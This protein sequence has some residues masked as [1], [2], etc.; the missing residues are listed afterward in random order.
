MIVGVEGSRNF[1]DYSIFLRGM[2]TALSSM[3]ENDK[4][5]TIMSAGPVRTNEMVME[6]SNVSERTLKSLGIKV[7][8]VKVPHK[9]FLKNMHVIDHFLYFTLPKETISELVREAEDKDVDVGVY[10]YP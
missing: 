2:R 8:V 10:R 4:Q 9:W 7:K 1:T 5:F 3:K 6:F